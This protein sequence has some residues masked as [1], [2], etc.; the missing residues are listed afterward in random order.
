MFGAVRQRRTAPRT[1]C[2]LRMGMSRRRCLWSAARAAACARNSLVFT[3]G[4]LI[5]SESA[6]SRTLSCS[7]R[8]GRG[9]RRYFAGSS[10]MALRTAVSCLHSLKDIDAAIR[11]GKRRCQDPS[12]AGQIGLWR[13]RRYSC[14]TSLTAIRVIQVRKLALGPEAS[15]MTPSLQKDFL[16]K[17]IFIRCVRE[18]MD[19]MR[20]LPLPRGDPSRRQSTRFG[21]PEPVRL[22]RDLRCR[23]LGCHC[24]LRRSLTEKSR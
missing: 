12:S 14:I 20:F 8:G 5:W 22:G 16:N 21:P 19:R 4:T 17:V 7:D 18:V 1:C 10:A 24:E 9:S 15:E 13:S 6:V 3:N 23:G 2:V 11:T